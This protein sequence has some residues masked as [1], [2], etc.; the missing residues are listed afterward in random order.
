MSDRP[1]GYLQPFEGE[2][3][4]HYLGRYRRQPIVSVSSPI[5][6]GLSTGCGSIFYRW[7]HLYFNPRPTV[8]EISLVCSVIGLREEELKKM[9]PAS[10][11]SVLIQPIRLCALCYV[12]HPWH[13]MEWQYKSR[14]SCMLHGV[15]L[16]SLCPGCQ[17]KFVLPCFW[18]EW[19]VCDRCGYGFRRMYRR[20]M[21]PKD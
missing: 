11:E 1:I 15:E 19:M 14:A 9:L 3:I 20:Q 17:K 5:S 10:D 4:S 13:L 7:E 12:N 6:F 21:E 16:M 18:T 8:E 2:S